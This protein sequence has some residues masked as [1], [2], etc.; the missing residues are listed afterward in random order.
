MRAGHDEPKNDTIV[1][2]DHFFRMDTGVWKDAPDTGVV[3][4]HTVEA[5]FDSAIAVE[6]DIGRI[7]IEVC[8]PARRLGKTHE[9]VFDSFSV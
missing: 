2:L 7:Q 6:D 8:C 4:L 3:S 5:R 9:S 1:D